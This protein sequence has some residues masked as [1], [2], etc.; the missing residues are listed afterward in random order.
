LETVT[1]T[2]ALSKH[3]RT[4]PKS[5]LAR[6]TLPT[7]LQPLKHAINTTAPATALIFISGTL[8]TPAEYKQTF[9]D[10]DKHIEGNTLHQITKSTSADRNCC[11]K[12]TPQSLMPMQ[13]F[14]CVMER[15]LGN[16]GVV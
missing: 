13:N 14:T 8:P 6:H 9:L 4:T 11:E 15:I 2:Q 16:M 3:I 10:V 1:Q 12:P 5:S 7:Y